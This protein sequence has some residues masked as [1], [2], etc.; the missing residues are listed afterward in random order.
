MNVFIIN[1]YVCDENKNEVQEFTNILKEQLERYGVLYTNITHD[2]VA[3]S[4]SRLQKNS[5]VIVYN[6]HKLDT[7][8]ADENISFLQKAKKLNSQIWPVAFDKE[9][10]D[11]IGI[12]SEKQSY[13]VWEQ[14]RCRNLDTSYIPQIA[15]IFSRKIISRVFPV[16]YSEVGEIFL[17]HRRIDGEEIAAKIY[18]KIKI[19]AKDMNPFRDVVEVNVGENAQEEIDK[20]M[21]NSEVFIF[22]HTDKSGESEWI[23]KELYFALLKNIPILWINIDGATSSNLRLKPSDKPHLFYNSK[24]FNDQN[25]L[26]KIVDEILQKSFELIMENSNDVIEYIDIFKKLFGTNLKIKD[27]EN[28]I[29][30]VMME[31]KG[32]SYPQRK[33]KQYFQL[34]GRTPTVKDIKNLKRLET[35]FNGDSIAILSKK[36]TNLS[37][38]NNIV[39]E[40]LD[41]FYYNWNAYIN[42]EERRKGMEIVISGAFPDCDEIYKQ[43]LTDALIIF[44]KA[45]LRNG[46]ILTFG[47]HPT[48]QELFFH[49]AKMIGKEKGKNMLKMYISDYYLEDKRTQEEYYKKKCN[50]V[51]TKKGMSEEASISLMRKRMIQRKEV[52]ALICLGGKIKNNKNEEGIR[53]EIKLATECNIPVF[54]IGSVGGCSAKVAMEYKNTWDMLNHASSEFNEELL[55]G[56]DYFKMVQNILRYLGC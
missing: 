24:D 50:M 28:M 42:G 11:P 40:S 52:K 18:D 53:E 20:V 54:I 38:Q 17:S 7:T 36:V 29:Y 44:S 21:I 56:I 30:E 37:I 6:E 34:M 35:D 13:D 2:N 48:F 51:A 32:Y 26:S 49:I 8:Q 41:D 47:A 10:R 25:K 45:I 16:L 14:L 43:N 27:N 1:Q 3:I 22:I 31:R 55:R 19:Q 39:V 9:H 4:K 33:I 12:I 23:L 46:Y 5:I 15:L